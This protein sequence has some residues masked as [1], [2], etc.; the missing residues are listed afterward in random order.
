MAE[1]GTSSGISVAWRIF[2]AVTLVTL[3]VVLIPG[4]HF[5]SKHITDSE[6][7]LK[8]EAVKSGRLVANGVALLVEADEDLVDS[9][10]HAA[11]SGDQFLFVN[12]YGVDG[13][14]L[15][16]SGDQGSPG[17]GKA[18]W[19]ED[20]QVVL[21]GS[22]ARVVA[23]IVSQAG[24]RRMLVAGYDGTELLREARRPRKA[25]SWLLV[26]LFFPLV[27]VSLSL[28]G[29][30]ARRLEALRRISE[31]ISRGVLSSP[32]VG[33]EH[34]DEVGAASRALDVMLANLK[35]LE[36]FL[37][38][39][40]EGDLSI[41]LEME[42]QLAAA[43]N[44]L[45]ANQR[46]LVSGLQGTSVS[47]GTASEQF[48]AN[49]KRQDEGASEQSSAVEETRRAM[50]VGV[51]VFY[52]QG[53]VGGLILAPGPG[54]GTH[55]ATAIRVQVH[56]RLE[57]VPLTGL[58]AEIHALFDAFVVGAD[59]EGAVVAHELNQVALVDYARRTHAAPIAI[60]ANV[61][62]HRVVRHV[63]MAGEAH[64]PLEQWVGEGLA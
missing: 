22:V 9:A 10:I 19:S 38:R 43:A 39:V 33:D 7:R 35:I 6:Q 18:E 3:L 50:G 21:V 54:L 5:T 25:L 55:H 64:G 48:M 29:R 44:Q 12:I 27:L 32:Y 53:P 63:G 30:L 8:S 46:A 1:G 24:R 45:V 26:G 20:P 31:D 41:T 61:H 47:I 49:A 36:T 2:G 51:G 60:G 14:A 4:W 17:V 13:R 62:L 28:G 15:A 23:P 16:L 58:H 52:L 56:T 42:G 34:S 40:A 59:L 11:A 57:R 37:I